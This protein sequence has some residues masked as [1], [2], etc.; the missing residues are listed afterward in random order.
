M[1]KPSDKYEITGIAGNASKRKFSRVFFGVR[2]D[3][4]QKVVI[5]SLAKT[6]D[7]L[8]LQQRLQEEALFSF[9]QDGLP[10]VLDYFEE[11][12]EI[13]LVL[14]FKEGVS[15]MEFVKTLKQKQKPQFVLNL[16]KKLEPILTELREKQIVHL[17]IKPGNIIVNGAADDF[18]VFL[19]DFGMAKEISNITQRKTLFPLGYAA[20]ELILNRLHLAAHRTDIFALGITLWQIFTGRIPLIHPIHL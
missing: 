18:E 10:Q 4:G 7:N 11:D 20:P 14:A 16:L 13:M 8:H 1:I 3:N 2:K 5:K 9:Q 17:D 6:Q 19:I 12:T 15:L